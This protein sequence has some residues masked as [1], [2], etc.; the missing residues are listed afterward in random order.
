M[1]LYFRH[2]FGGKS[3]IRKKKRDQTDKTKR[4]MAEPNQFVAEPNQFDIVG[5][6]I[7]QKGLIGENIQV[8]TVLRS[9]NRIVEP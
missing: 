7:T 6:L 9:R 2:D 4:I 5:T 8:S 3:F 1:I